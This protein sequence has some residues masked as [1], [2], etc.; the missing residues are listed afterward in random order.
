MF[1][2]EP[3]LKSGSE[4]YELKGGAH[5]SSRRRFVSGRGCPQGGVEGALPIN[6]KKLSECKTWM[7]EFM[8]FSFLFFPILGKNVNFTRWNVI[9]VSLWLHAMYEEA[10][11]AAYEQ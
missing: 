4:L 6:V 5:L 11:Q 10:R 9:E 7:K 8:I 3:T 1:N 2:L